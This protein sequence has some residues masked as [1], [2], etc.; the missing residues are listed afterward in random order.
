VDILCYTWNR[1]KVSFN[2]DVNLG[3]LQPSIV[4]TVAGVFTV[5]AAPTGN[6]L[7]SV[8]GRETGIGP[9]WKK[10]PMEGVGPVVKVWPGATLG[11]RAEL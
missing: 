10:V 4:Y 3:A 9:F 6:V 11:V 7:F 8:D 2:A 5:F 1:R